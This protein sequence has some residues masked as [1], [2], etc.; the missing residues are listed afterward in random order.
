MTTPS[1]NMSG[2]HQPSPKQV[3]DATTDKSDP[4]RNVPVRKGKGY[5]NTVKKR[6]RRWYDEFLAGSTIRQIADEEAPQITPLKV[7]K[8]IDAQAQMA[9]DELRIVATGICAHQLEQHQRIYQEALAA[10][11][12]SKE[13][14]VTASVQDKSGEATTVQKRKTRPGN[15]IFLRVASEALEVIRRLATES[16]T[17]KAPEIVEDGQWFSPK[18]SE[19]SRTSAN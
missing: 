7:A 13:P 11:E 19:I 2:D 8:A 15:A 18:I 6:H 12:R 10:W 5:D 17:E 14:E 4:P 3:Y 16:L 9:T 1:P